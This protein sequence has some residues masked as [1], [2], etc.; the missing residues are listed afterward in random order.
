MKS[1]GIRCCVFM[2]TLHSYAVLGKWAEMCASSQHCQK[3]IFTVRVTFHTSH[4]Y[5]QPK[6]VEHGMEHYSDVI[7]STRV[8]QITSLIIVYSTIYS[9]ADQ[10]KHQ[11]SAS[12]AFVQGIHQWPVNSPHD[13]PVM[14]KM[15]PFD[16]VIMKSVPKRPLAIEEAE[17]TG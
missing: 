2:C 17:L 13:G 3:S 15:F 6:W 12:L 7:M 10:R 9:S 8:S 11:S 5:Q 16:D 14:W 1:H 4:F